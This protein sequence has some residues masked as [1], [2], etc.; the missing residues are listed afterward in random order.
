MDKI[1]VIEDSK[2]MRT[3]IM[4]ILESM[5]FDNIVGLDNAEVIFECPSI[6]LD[7]TKLVITDIGLPGAN[8]VELAKKINSFNKYKNIPIIF[9]TAYSK[10]EIVNE[11]IKAGAID[12]L[13]KPIKDDI[14]EQRVAKVLGIAINN[15][16]KDQFISIDV[17]K[18]KIDMECHRSIR[19]KQATAFLIIKVDEKHLNNCIAKIKSILRKID[20]VYLIKTMQILILLP[21]TAKEGLEV[22]EGKIVNELSADKIK[23]LEKRKAFFDPEAKTPIENLFAELKLD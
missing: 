15:S 4:S 6:Y 9:V 17:G 8:G 2:L 7:N 23:I 10:P 14:L 22:V 21:S 18:E 11:A 1:L 12:Y 3:K 13:V 19:S 16:L 5:G 20:M